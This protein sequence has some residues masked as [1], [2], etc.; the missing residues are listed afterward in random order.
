M[1]G[2]FTRRRIMFQHWCFTTRISIE[3]ASM[4]RERKTRRLLYKHQYVLNSYVI[5]SVAISGNTSGIEIKLTVNKMTYLLRQVT[6]Y[7]QHTCKQIQEAKSSLTRW[8]SLIRTMI[9]TICYWNS[10]VNTLRT[11]DADLRF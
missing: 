5:L 3:T 7:V 11:G 9:S 8:H 6:G 2:R 10:K 1:D 4:T